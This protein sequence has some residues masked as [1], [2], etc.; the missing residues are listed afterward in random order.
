MT[1]RPDP[2][3]E[4]A[5]LG[6]AYDARLVRRLW[7]FVRPHR[8]WLLFSLFLMPVS[9]LAGLAQPYLIK[10]VIDNH[11]VPGALSG[12]GLVLAAFLAASR[13]EF[14][15]RF[16]QLYWMNLAGQRVVLDLRRELFAWSCLGT[17]HIRSR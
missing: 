10:V 3:R 5:I 1:M 15:A 8:R 14:A 6:R 16:G 13:L 4:E 7:P 11:I 12:I 17:S 2:F 9:T